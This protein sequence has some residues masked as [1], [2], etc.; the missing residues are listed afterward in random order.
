[1]REAAESHRG[2]FPEHAHA[3]G[4]NMRAKL[5]RCLTVGDAE[6]EGGRRRLAEYRGG[7]RRQSRESRDSSRRIIATCPM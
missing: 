1:M 2:L 6:F 4:A 3:Y 7:R 5:E